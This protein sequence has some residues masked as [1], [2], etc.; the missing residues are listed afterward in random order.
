MSNANVAETQITLENA[1]VA[2]LHPDD[3]IQIDWMELDWGIS[4][5]PTDEH[6]FLGLVWSDTDEFE[7]KSQN[8]MRDN[9]IWFSQQEYRV[10]TSVGVVQT[11]K[12]YD[13]VWDP[14]DAQVGPQQE[15]DRLMFWAAS[16]TTSNIAGGGSINYDYITRQYKFRDN[17]DDWAGWLW[18]E[19]IYHING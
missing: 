5:D 7:D 19:T 9:S 6:L 3:Q 11:M 16:S 15:R 14:E 4:D 12:H 1:K 2:L 17:P 13:Q 8:T 10:L 18:E